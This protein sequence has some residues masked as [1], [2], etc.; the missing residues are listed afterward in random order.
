[1]YVSRRNNAISFEV[2][3]HKYMILSSLSYPLSA[4]TMDN[5]L[6]AD[7]FVMIGWKSILS[8]FVGALLILMVHIICFSTSAPIDNFIHFLLSLALSV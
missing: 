4:T 7:V 8:C 3:S 6:M 5:G 1:M 2:F